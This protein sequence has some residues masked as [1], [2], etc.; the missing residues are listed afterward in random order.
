MQEAGVI[1]DY[2]ESLD[3]A[4]GFDRS[5]S[6]CVRQEVEDHLREAADAD[7][8]GDRLEAE[9]HAVANFGDPQAIAA[10]FVLVSLTRQ[11]RRLGAATILVIIGV[12][13]VMKARI[14]WYTFT[15]WTTSDDMKAVSEIVLLIDRYAFLLSLIVGIG[16][17]AY[18]SSC[19]IAPVL[20]AGYRKQLG[21]SFVLCLAAT[22]SLALSVIG[23]GVLTALKLRGTPFC[24]DALIPVVS[25]A[26]E[27][28]CI[29]LLVFQMR[30]MTWQTR[31]TAALL[32][33]GHTAAHPR[34]MQS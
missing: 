14:A 13:A 16:G 31:S 26:I 9:R 32:K 23:D 21:R 8:A 6:Q 17:W 30:R 27:V 3:R 19:R 25:M 33:A 22:T 29:G 15:Q 24:A 1:S 4:L 11:V 7:P 10:Q 34:S 12:W 28:I 2:L 18:I 5:L 20:D